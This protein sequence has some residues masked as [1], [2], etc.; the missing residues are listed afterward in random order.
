MNPE[1]ILA[2]MGDLYENMTAVQHENGA[3]RQRVAELEAEL[4]ART[5][6]RS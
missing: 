4:A 1:A 3:L 6:G 5:G 2:L